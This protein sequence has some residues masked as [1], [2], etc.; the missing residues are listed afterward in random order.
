MCKITDLTLLPL[1]T[2]CYGSSHHEV[3]GRKLVQKFTYFGETYRVGG[4]IEMFVPETGAL[5]LEAEIIS[6]G[7]DVRVKSR[8][9]APWLPTNRR[10]ILLKVSRQHQDAGRT[11]DHVF[12]AFLWSHHPKRIR[13]AALE[14]LAR[15]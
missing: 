6:S 13:H 11:P 14:T 12:G 15:I 10:A 3:T 9:S 2:T 4:V 5:Y 7:S 1:W 8:A